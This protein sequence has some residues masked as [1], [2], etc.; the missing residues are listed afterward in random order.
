MVI[1]TGSTSSA[2]PFE[3][4]EVIGQEGTAVEGG[5]ACGYVKQRVLELTLL[6]RGEEEGVGLLLLLLL[7]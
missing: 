5:R 7:L 4:L 2:C 1:E 3:Y 6:E